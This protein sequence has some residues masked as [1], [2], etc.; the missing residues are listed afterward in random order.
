MKVKTQM[1][2]QV[3]GNLSK[4]SVIKPKVAI[5]PLIIDEAALEHVSVN[6]KGKFSVAVRKTQKIVDTED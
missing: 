4:L 2:S 6:S 1:S 3:V 5:T